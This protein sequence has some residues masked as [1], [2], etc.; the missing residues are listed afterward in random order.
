MRGL[1]KHFPSPLESVR[2]TPEFLGCSTAGETVGVRWLETEHGGVRA[3]GRSSCPLQWASWSRAR[4]SWAVGW[5]RRSSTL[6]Y[7][8]RRSRVVDWFQ[9]KQ[10]LRN[11]KKVEYKCLSPNPPQSHFIIIIIFDA[12]EKCEIKFLLL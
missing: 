4:R 1:R 9:S 5:G 2:F 6:S 10:N 8:P 3:G 11:D 12:P 7:T